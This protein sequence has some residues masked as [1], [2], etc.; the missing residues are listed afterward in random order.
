VVVTSPF[1]QLRSY[2]TF[3]CAVNQMLPPNRR[4]KVCTLTIT[5]LPLLMSI[6]WIG[7]LPV[8]HVWLLQVAEKRHVC[9]HSLTDCCALPSTLREV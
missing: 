9:F 5:G 3:R 2:L 6:A 4:M 1:H 7:K 8:S